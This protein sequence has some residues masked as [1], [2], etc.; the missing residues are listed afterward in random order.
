MKVLITNDDGINSA[1]LHMLVK[2]VEKIII[3]W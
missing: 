1:G 3:S 2:E